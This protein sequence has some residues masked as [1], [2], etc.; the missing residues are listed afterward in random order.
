[1]TADEK[2]FLKSLH[3]EMKDHMMKGLPC[4]IMLPYESFAR[5]SEYLK[6]KGVIGKK[7]RT[8]KKSQTIVNDSEDFEED[9]GYAIP[10]IGDNG[11]PY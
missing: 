9:P 5:F 10:G 3:Q 7:N 6:M 8:T 1:M 2:F 4:T 11:I